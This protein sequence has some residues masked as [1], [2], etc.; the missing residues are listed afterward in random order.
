MRI[1][2]THR[3]TIIPVAALALLT[4]CF[5]QA[6]ILAGEP[7]RIVQAGTTISALQSN[8]N[9]DGVVILSSSIPLGMG[10][11]QTMRFTLFNPPNSQREPLRVHVNI[12]DQSG[13][14]IAESAEA[15]IPP[16]EFRSFDFNRSNIPLAGDTGTGRLQV[17]GTIF[18]IEHKDVNG[19]IRDQFPTAIEVLDS[20]M[21]IGQSI[22]VATGA[23]SPIIPW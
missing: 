16:G 15:T 18:V 22:T 10:R 13:N 23:Y 19:V 5:F 17:R 1:K 12:Y 6:K 11:G 9:D 3:I 7:A 2:S 8:P 14:L 21:G 4:L 20:R